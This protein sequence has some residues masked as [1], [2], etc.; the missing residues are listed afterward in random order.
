MSESETGTLEMKSQEPK[1]NKSS[2]ETES[3]Q[4]HIINKPAGEDRLTELPLMAVEEWVLRVRVS[5]CSAGIQDTSIVAARIR[6]R[7]AAT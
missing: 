2:R 3:R 6:S 7:R 1:P 4:E 5:F